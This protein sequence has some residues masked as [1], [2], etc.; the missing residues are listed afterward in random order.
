MQLAAEGY[1]NAQ[2][3]CQLV[4]IA[5]KQADIQLTIRPGDRIHVKDIQF[6][7]DSALHPKEL[8]QALRALRTRRILGWPLFPSYSAEAVDA[9][10]ARLRSLYL[11][12]GYFG[13]TVRLDSTE[14]HGKEAAVRIRAEAGPLYELKQRPCD[15]CA[16]LFRARRE[17]ERRGI[18]DFSATLNVERETTT[19]DRGN[20]IRVG[21][22]EFAGH[23]HYTDAMLR[24]NFLLEEGQLLD[25]RLLRKSIDRLNR[26]NL[27]DPIDPSQVII[28]QSET[29]GVADVMV[30]LTERKRGAWR[31][32]GPVGPASFAGP[33][34]ASISSR[35]PPWGSGLFELA[36]YTASVSMYAFARPILPLLGVD[37]R[38]SLAP[39]LALARPFSPGEGWKSG[40]SIAPQLGWKASALA[41]SASQFEQRLLPVL[42]GD[43]GIV[44]DLPV[45]V[46]GPSG[47]GVMLC[48][49]RPPRFARLRYGATIAIRLLGA[50]TGL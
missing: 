48:E 33:L 35:L 1:A 6:I 3:D 5:P 27:F 14:I 24:R 12:K 15:L 50:F 36:T 20:P 11:S 10:L 25:G 16:A 41:Y 40:F 29:R 22:I 44:P 13:A 19:I 18:L 26:S 30:K 43:R 47:E 37:P 31:L 45:T 39:V 32:S 9:D 8:R 21:R 49:P 28:H 38:R 34:E 4:P 17:A 46:E 2:V 23:H 42:A 7:G